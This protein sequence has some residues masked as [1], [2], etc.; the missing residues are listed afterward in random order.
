MGAVFLIHVI[1][2]DM[3]QLGNILKTK[4]AWHEHG[5]GYHLLLQVPQE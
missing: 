4:V 2:Y 5:N 3:V 1:A